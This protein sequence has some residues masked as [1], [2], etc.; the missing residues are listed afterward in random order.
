MAQVREYQGPTVGQVGCTY[1]KLG[2]ISSGQMAGQTITQNSYL[3]PNYC[4]SGAGPNYPP[5]Y[6]TLSHGQAYNC[7]GY[8]NI[9]GAYPYA[10][11]VNCAT[12]FVQRPCTGSISCGTKEGYRRRKWF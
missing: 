1:S 3:V 6:N 4:S 7:G 5:P 9:K 12:N 2:N 11:C 8:F 10:D